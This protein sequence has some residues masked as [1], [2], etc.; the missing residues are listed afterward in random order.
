[1]VVL[2]AGQKPLKALISAMKF[3][4]LVGDEGWRRTW[5]LQVLMDNI[6]AAMNVTVAELHSTL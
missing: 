2:V 6:R 4:V 3:A 5:K 1:M